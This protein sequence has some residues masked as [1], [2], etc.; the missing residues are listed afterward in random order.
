[1]LSSIS[2][3]NMF[4]ARIFNDIKWISVFLNFCFVLFHFLHFSFN[5][6][7]IAGITSVMF[8]IRNSV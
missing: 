6:M 4:P 2:K 8:A 1:M 3:I 7:R 5:Y